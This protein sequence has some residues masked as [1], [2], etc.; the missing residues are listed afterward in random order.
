MDRS[1]AKARVARQATRS[2]RIGRA[3]FV[4]MNMGT[5]EE[6]EEMVRRAWEWIERLRVEGPDGDR[7]AGG[8]G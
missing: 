8:T 7:P 1:D 4:I 3:D 6:L 2:E 5:L